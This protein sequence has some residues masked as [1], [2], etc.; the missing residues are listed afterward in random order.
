MNF[1]K[2]AI[3]LKNEDI[4]KPE[5]VATDDRVMQKRLTITIDEEVYKGLYKVVGRGGISR[6][7]EDLVRPHV[8]EEEVSEEFSDSEVFEWVDALISEPEETTDAA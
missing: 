2:N 7:I 8:V 3:K 1:S 5:T 4:L 6:F